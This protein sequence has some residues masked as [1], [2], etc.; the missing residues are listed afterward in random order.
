MSLC[1]YMHKCHGVSRR[2]TCGSHFS[3]S[4]LYTLGFEPMSSCLGTSAFTFIHLATP[5]T[6]LR[7]WEAGAPHA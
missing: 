1:V 3:P 7:S 2:I 4:T 5:R 6:L